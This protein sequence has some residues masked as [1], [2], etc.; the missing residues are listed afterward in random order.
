MI[1]NLG[2]LARKHV[3]VFVPLRDPQLDHWRRT[4]PESPLA[5]NRAITAADFANERHSVLR[6]L[7]RLG[8]Q[9][10]DSEPQK[11]STE[12]INRYLDIK[13]KEKI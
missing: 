1:E 12:L 11:I 9:T 2:R 13:R 8:L 6:R 10:I 7:D 4:V 3:V 5:M